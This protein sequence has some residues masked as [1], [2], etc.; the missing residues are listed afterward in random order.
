MTNQYQEAARQE[1]PSAKRVVGSGPYVVEIA[2]GATVTLWPTIQEAEAFGD[3]MEELGIEG[4]VWML[5]PW[6]AETTEAPR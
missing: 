5:A 3:A 6:R 4:A 1:H 2:D